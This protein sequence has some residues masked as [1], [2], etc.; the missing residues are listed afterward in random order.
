MTKAT[1]P[2]AP[3]RGAGILPAASSGRQDAC[4]TSGDVNLMHAPTLRERAEPRDGYEPVPPLD[5]QRVRRAVVLGRMVSGD[6]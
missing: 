2:S 1:P 3:P 4:T 6:V 5:G